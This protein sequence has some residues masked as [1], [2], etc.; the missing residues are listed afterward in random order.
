[1]QS[2]SLTKTT[3]F[4]KLQ[5]LRSLSFIFCRRVVTSLTLYTP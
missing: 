2:M 3:V 4:F 5:F 1:M